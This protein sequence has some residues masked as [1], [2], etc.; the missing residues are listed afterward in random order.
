[1]LSLKDLTQEGKTQSDGEKWAE[2]LNKYKDRLSEEVDEETDMA[3]ANVERVRVM[4]ATNPKQV[5]RA[6]H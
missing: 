3:E 5:Y 2:W 6:Q 4:N 1:M